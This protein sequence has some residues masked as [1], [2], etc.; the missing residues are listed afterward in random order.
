MTIPQ[1]GC[2]IH[3]PW[4]MWSACDQLQLISAAS[5][6]SPCWKPG[7]L[8]SL[9]RDQL[10][11]VPRLSELQLWS[12]WDLILWALLAWSAQRTAAVTS[13]LKVDLKWQAWPHGVC[14]M[15]MDQYLLISF[16][17]GWTSI[18]TQ[19]FWCELQGYKVLTHPQIA[20]IPGNKMQKGWV[21]DTSEWPRA[22]P[23]G[24]AACHMQTSSDGQ[25]QFWC[26]ICLIN[27]TQFSS[28]L[29]QSVKRDNVYESTSHTSWTRN[30]MF[31]VCKSGSDIN[32]KAAWTGSPWLTRYRNTICL[33]NQLADPALLLWLH[34]V[35]S[36][37]PQAESP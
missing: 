24:H 15:G 14:Q 8:P 30:T 19:L 27:R 16:L 9:L 26:L 10:L 36:R 3:R 1:N 21:L 35:E 5:L 32:L 13:R 37:L 29:I 17:V 20:G 18:L 11:S 12:P 25:N 2:I 33:R 22:W 7:V 28:L 4:H 6:P 31:S 23:T 34:P